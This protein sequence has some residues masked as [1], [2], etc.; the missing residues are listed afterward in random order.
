MRTEEITRATNGLLLVVT[1]EWNNGF[2]L[3]DSRQATEAEQVQYQ[4][5]NAGKAYESPVR[6]S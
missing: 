5:A 4:A 6:L 1:W 2:N 3:V